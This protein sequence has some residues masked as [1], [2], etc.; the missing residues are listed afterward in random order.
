MSVA[1]YREEQ[2]FRVDFT[3]FIAFIAQYV[4]LL[5][6]YCG[7]S[8]S[9]GLVID[10]GLSGVGMGIFL[11]CI[12]LGVFSLVLWLAIHRMRKENV[13][14]E[15]IAN[16]AM[17][18]AEDASGFSKN[19]FHT[20]FR[21]IF[22]TAVPAT[23]VLAFHYT[24]VEHTKE[25]QR[26]GI[27]SDL[28]NGGVIFSLRGPHQI[29]KTEKEAF[30]NM[31]NDNHEFEAV[32]VVSLPA[33]MLVPVPG[34]NDVHIRMIPSSVLLAMRPT[35][36]THV[37][38]PG[39]WLRLSHAMPHAVN[40]PCLLPPTCIV[41][42]YKLVAALD[43][44]EVES[45]ATLGAASTL[46]KALTKTSSTKSAWEDAG[47][48]MTSEA[49][50]LRLTEDVKASDELSS[51]LVGLVGNVSI[52]YPKTISEYCIS[53][54][55]IR[56]ACKASSLTVMYHYTQPDI[57]SFILKG[58]MRM[59][60]QGQGDGGVYFSTL[61]PCS[62][63]L[64][65]YDY[66]E[67]LIKDCF[68]VERLE[69]Y[70][71]QDR[72]SAVIVSACHPATLQPAP[73]GRDRAKVVSKSDFSA[74]SLPHVDG[75]YFLRPDRILGVFYIDPNNQP[76]SG[77]SN[78][79]NP[80]ICR[81]KEH[82]A[83]CIDFITTSLEK[84]T[85]IFSEVMELSSDLILGQDGGS[86]DFIGNR[87]ELQDDDDMS[88]LLIDDDVF[89]LNDQHSL[90]RL[91]QIQSSASQRN[92]SDGGRETQNSVPSTSP[93]SM[94][95]PSNA[96]GKHWST[97]RNKVQ[98]HQA[99]E[100]QTHQMKTQHDSSSDQHTASFSNSGD[101]IRRSSVENAVYL[102]GHRIRTSSSALNKSTSPPQPIYTAPPP[103]PTPP[104]GVY[105]DNGFDSVATML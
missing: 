97:L 72:L 30:P 64:G 67:N 96:R 34:I 39:P 18:R 29:T 99:L 38:D 31:L 26:S 8:L 87:E 83:E 90:Y 100:Q 65:G 41:R 33:R 4:I 56:V 2:P 77:A 93:S 13:S 98:A 70:K 86:G 14:K 82:D 54:A 43:D 22:N 66:E 9:T 48:E 102:A 76:R 79:R 11:V 59:S 52:Q 16:N 75:N 73:G 94:L 32:V 5:V 36:F 84:Q 71:G 46:K 57:V 40:G 95:D 44:E 103:P 17:R 19:K 61:G 28:L 58:G 7:L 6:Y 91:S 23:H 55:R 62:Y 68:G 45:N 37:F 47:L 21:A 78:V 50:Q 92:S 12:V 104:S 15:L 10:F 24:K 20:T 69:E 63:G 101:G 88:D 3:N 25:C 81:E 53:M 27:K 85:E 42:T 51:D 80:L 105:Q 60:T 49:T 1:F 89:N 35:A 74:F